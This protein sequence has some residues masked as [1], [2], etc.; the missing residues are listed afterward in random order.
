[1]GLLFDNRIGDVPW[2]KL[3]VRELYAEI[4]YP[5]GKVFEDAGTTYLLLAQ[6]GAAAFC[7]APLYFY[8]LRAGSI[9]HSV[10]S[11]GT[12][13]RYEMHLRRYRYI[14]ARY[15][16]LKINKTSFLHQIIESIPYLPPE[17]RAEAAAEAAAIVKS[18]GR[19]LSL[20]T[21]LKSL[22]IRTVPD[23]YAWNKKRKKEKKLR[24][25]ARS[26]PR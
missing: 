14:V 12:L 24:R 3:C 6:C 16:E 23:L 1:M 15:P 20:K 9:T 17:V 26:S 21:R 19:E 4:R 18:L 25:M 5:L 11:K 8:R 22:A 7:P 13:D 2:N 10:T